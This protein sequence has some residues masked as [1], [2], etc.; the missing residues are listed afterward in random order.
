LLAAQVNKLLRTAYPSV[1][2]GAVMRDFFGP[3]PTSQSASVEI[4]LFTSG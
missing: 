3:Q 4:Y 2:D 1:F